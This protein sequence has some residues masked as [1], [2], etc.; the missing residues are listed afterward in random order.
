MIQSG[1]ITIYLFRHGK[2]DGH[3]GD[4]PL[5]DDAQ[6]D[7]DRAGSF[8][9]A[10]T[11]DGETV[12]LLATK[13]VRSHDTAKRL[14][15]VIKAQNP[16]LTIEGVHDEYAVRNPDLYLAGHRVEMV[17][18]GNAMSR[19]LP[20]DTI[21]GDAIEKL[22]FFGDFFRAPDRIGYWLFHDNPPGENATAVARRLLN[23]CRSC[24][25]TSPEKNLSIV[26]VSHSPV[27]RAILVAYMGLSDPG[28]PDWVEPITIR[29]GP[30]GS[31]IQ[32]RDII[33][34]LVV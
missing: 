12:L 34:P 31:T 17:S 6:G 25:D 23:Y 26:A 10:H 3:N 20:E 28:E 32:F 15:E 8:V 7:I 1:N 19:Q 14:G 11:P 22:P 18:N 13:T 21:S 2:V 33:Q 29:L 9:A 4:V 30:T 27:L 5:S 16:A 24:A